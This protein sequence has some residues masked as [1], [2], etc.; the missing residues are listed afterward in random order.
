MTSC[1]LLRVQQEVGSPRK[2][3]ATYHNS[4]FNNPSYDY[5][6]T[7]PLDKLGPGDAAAAIDIT[8]GTSD[9]IMYTKRAMAALDRKDPRF[10]S[11]REFIG[12]RD[13]KSV[14]RYTRT[15]RTGTPRWRSSDSSHLWHY[16]ISLFR[17]DLNNEANLKGIAEVLLGKSISP[18]IGT[19]NDEGVF[20]L[21]DLKK[22][23]NGRQVVL[24]QTML[25]S[26][27]FDP[28]AKD[29]D[30]GPKTAASVL[31][32]RKS[33]GSSAKDGDTMTP[34][35]VTQLQGALAKAHA[36]GERG[37]K[38]DT[39]PRGP[40]GPTGPRGLQGERGPAGE[41]GKDGTVTGELVIKNLQ[42]EHNG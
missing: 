31:A 25:H 5:S 30:Y 37:P 16:H 4:R 26:A 17:A 8:C 19:A 13:G 23:D 28:G 32:M 36:E 1:A 24:L 29:G 12:T 34:W 20:D 14:V 18:S 42:F 39:G 9:M 21:L 6:V 33:M 22:G 10:K 41:D 40:Q 3:A 11:V 35:A 15:S 38:G 7:L 27:G 2:S